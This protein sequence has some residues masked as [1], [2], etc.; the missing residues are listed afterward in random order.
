MSE[1][2]T[3]IDQRRTLA[4][5][6]EMLASTHKLL[7]EANKLHIDARIAPW[8]AAFAGFSAGALVIGAII[9]AMKV[10]GG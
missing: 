8:Q 6:D 2:D 7:M 10:L 3:P 1:N 9:T 5:I 4:E